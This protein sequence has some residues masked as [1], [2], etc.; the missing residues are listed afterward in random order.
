MDSAEVAFAIDDVPSNLVAGLTMASL[1]IN[2]M[3][4][5]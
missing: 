1:L 4:V 3:G 5:M 2:E